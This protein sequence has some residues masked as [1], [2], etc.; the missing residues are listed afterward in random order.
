MVVAALAIAGTGLSAYGQMRQGA[1]ADA[2]ARKQSSLINL[3]ADEIIARAELNNMII[4]R[5]FKS[6]QGEQIAAAAGAGVDVGAGMTLEILEQTAMDASLQKELNRR[7]ARCEASVLRFEAS[8][9][10]LAGKEAKKAATIGAAGSLLTG[11]GRFA[12]LSG[13]GGGGGGTINRGP[14]KGGG[15][16]MTWNYQNRS[17]GHA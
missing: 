6:L 3:Q 8:M 5:N 9:G 2:A 15:G 1:W 12:S 13:G 11:F 10:V 16:R 7:D 14:H 17:A 4:D